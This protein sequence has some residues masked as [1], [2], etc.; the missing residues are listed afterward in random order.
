MTLGGSAAVVPDLVGL[1]VAV[2]RELGSEAG[3]VV[4]SADLDGPPLGELAWP[5]AWV[6]T[7]QDPGP[8]TRVGRGAVVRIAL[9]GGGGS[10][11]AGDRE[12]R[13]PPP[14]PDSL[15]AAA[16]PAG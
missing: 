11:E 16:E 14:D 2:A 3:V 5:G 15:T 10:G 8:G 4:T 12:P 6:V 13:L 9:V 7:G 1:E